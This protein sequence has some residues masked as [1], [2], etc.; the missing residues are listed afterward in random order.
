MGE[1][2]EE[3]RQEACIRNRKMDKGGDRDLGMRREARV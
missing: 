2:V 3:K 1:G